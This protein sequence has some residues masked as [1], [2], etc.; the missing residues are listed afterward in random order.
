M[1]TSVIIMLAITA[2]LIILGFIFNK[3]KLMFVVQM[4]WMWIVI[5]FNNGGV[6]TIVYTN[7][8]RSFST[9]SNIFASSDPLYHLFC[10]GAGVIGWD[11]N[12]MNIILTIF[13]LVLYYISIQR[14]TKKVGIAGSLLLIYPFVENI[15]QKRNFLASAFVIFAFSYLFSDKKNRKLIFTI[16]IFIAAQIHSSAYIYIIFLFLQDIETRKLKKIIKFV[17]PIAFISIP[18]MPKIAGILF[19]ASKVNLYFYQLKTSL[20]DAVCWIVL[21]L[22]FTLIIAKMHKQNSSVLTEE[23]R[24][25][26]DRIYKM[27]LIS[28][29][30][31][32]LYYYEATFVRIYRNLLVFNYILVANRQSRKT[33]K[34][35][36][37]LTT[38][39]V[40]YLIVVYL[41]IY[42]IT[43]V[44]YDTLVIPSFENNIIFNAIFGG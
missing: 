15:I 3:S 30:F 44:G 10:Y 28:L 43:G 7:M 29:L 22:I 31:L 25:L 32:P 36:I 12:T 17:L 13:A 4:I 19:S 41:M 18:I 6:D 2:M 42:V 1:E 38:G 9:D 14:L 39:W 27:N 33:S 20:F 37:I 8:F 16:F 5:G 34:N 21:Q 24:K 35:N 11:F 40:G 23:D 26:E